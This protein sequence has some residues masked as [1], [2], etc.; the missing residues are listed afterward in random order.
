MCVCHSICC[1]SCTGEL[2]EAGQHVAAVVE[3][4]EELQ[5]VLEAELEVGRVVRGRDLHRARAE[6]AVDALVA[7]DRQQVRLAVAR[8]RVTHLPACTSQQ[9]TMRDELFT[10]FTTSYILIIPHPRLTEVFI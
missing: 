1:V 2:A 3:D 9:R 7:D 8:E 10:R 4:G 6:R 5:L